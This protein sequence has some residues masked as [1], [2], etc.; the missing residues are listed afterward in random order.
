MLWYYRSTGDLAKPFAPMA[1]VGGGW[2]IYN[3][4]V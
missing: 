4:L 3:T 2:G 1:K